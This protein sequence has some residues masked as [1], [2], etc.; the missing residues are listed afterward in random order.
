MLSNKMVDY[1]YSLT[2]KLYY[3]ESKPV[4]NIK[5][6]GRKCLNGILFCSF[7]RVESNK[8]TGFLGSYH[9]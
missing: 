6:I 5:Y 2:L 7:A 1:F 9:L 4:W 3:C 8:F